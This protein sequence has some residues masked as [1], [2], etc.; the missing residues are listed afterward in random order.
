MVADAIGVMLRKNRREF[1]SRWGF[2]ANWPRVTS[3]KF[4]RNSR[5]TFWIT[6]SPEFWRRRRHPN[7]PQPA[8]AARVILVMSI[9]DMGIGVRASIGDKRQIARAP[10]KAD[11][12]ALGV[13]VQMGNS[14]F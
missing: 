14:R 1:C 7:L 3:W 6:R 2:F 12:I 10:W 8:Q 4:S 9:G 11:A 5:P 13:A